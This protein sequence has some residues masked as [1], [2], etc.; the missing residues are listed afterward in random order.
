MLVDKIGKEIK[1][2]NKGTVLVSI[3]KG[4]GGS[5]V[6]TYPFEPF[7]MNNKKDGT[8]TILQ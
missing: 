6:L 7:F 4:W 2:L 8:K 5:Q 1:V 3:H